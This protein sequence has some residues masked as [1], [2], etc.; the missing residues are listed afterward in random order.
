[1]INADDVLR[2]A[3]G[4]HGQEDAGELL[5]YALVPEALRLIER[6]VK[7]GGRT[8]ETGAGHSTIVFIAA[9]CEHTCIVPDPV[10]VDRIR[11]YCEQAGASTER[12]SFHVGPSERLLPSLDLPELD[13]VLIDGSHSFPQVFIDWFYTAGALRKGGVLLIDDVHLWTGRVLRDFLRDE[14]EWEMVDELGGR[15]S[16]FRKMAEVDL[17]K[18][19]VDQRY[20][21]RKSHL[22]PVSW[23]RMSASMLRHGHARDLPGHVRTAIRARLAR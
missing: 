10:E 12:V 13:V 2:D 4:I 17:D 16:V 19:W 7:A 18:L 21:A 1:M 8:L 5:T 6:V 9:Q 20:V 14:P 15:T 22:G 3:P 23:L 11:A